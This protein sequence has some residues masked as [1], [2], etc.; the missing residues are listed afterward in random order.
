MDSIRKLA[1]V[2]DLNR[3]GDELARID[4][5]ER[6]PGASEREVA[7]RLA[8]LENGRELMVEAFGRDPDVEGW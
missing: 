6:H 7:L 8:S 5:R 2:S 3:T 4:I 1:I